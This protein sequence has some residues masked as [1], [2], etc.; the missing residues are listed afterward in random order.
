VRAYD[1]ALKIFRDIGEKGYEA[2]TLAA[3]GRVKA[4]QGDFAAARALYEQA[5][6]LQTPLGVKGDLAQTQLALAELLCETNEA[7]DAARLL[8]AAL[9]EFQSEKK[10]SDQI[11]AQAI[12]SR[13]L[14]LQN[15]VAAARAAIDAAA[16]QIERAR[17]ID[18]LEWRLADARVRMAD[19]TYRAERV[20]EQAL[21]EARIHGLIGMQFEASLVLAEI[22]MTGPDPARARASWCNYRNRLDAR[23]MG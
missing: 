17:L 15:Q 6:A 7:P 18:R 3:I 10:G 16:P 20:A 21:T 4:Q 14:L 23:A 9:Q 8:R 12:L 13:A 11:R 5:L 19:T 2:G 22:Q 1:E